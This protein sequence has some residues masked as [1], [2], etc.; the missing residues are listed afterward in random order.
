MPKRRNTLNSREAAYEEALE[1]GDLAALEKITAGEDD[2]ES[3][4]L[5][6]RKRKRSGGTTAGDE[7]RYDPALSLLATNF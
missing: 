1:R 5:G 3:V 6:K 4:A 2:D 7:T